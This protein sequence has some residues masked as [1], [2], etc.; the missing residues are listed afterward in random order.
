MKRYNK[1]GYHAEH[2]EGK[3][4][5]FED[6]LR[7]RD[8]LQKIADGRGMVPDH[9]TVFMNGRV[10]VVPKTFNRNDMMDEARKALEGLQ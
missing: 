8:A 1:D 5:L 3:F 4:V 7:L 9:S 2:P 6:Y 10:P